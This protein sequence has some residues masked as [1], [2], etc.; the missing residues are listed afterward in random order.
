MALF[1]PDHLELGSDLKS[2]IPL[3]I[4]MGLKVKC[5]LIS[6]H[7]KANI[8]ANIAG[9]VILGKNPFLA[10]FFNRTVIEVLSEL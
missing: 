8:C 5:S 2:V 10:V 9:A 1:V 4:S 7:P 3:S 6:E